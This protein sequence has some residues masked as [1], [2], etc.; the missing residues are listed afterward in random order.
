MISTT[1]AKFYNASKN[2][3]VSKTIHILNHVVLLLKSTE[4]HGVEKALNVNIISLYKMSAFLP[5][6]YKICCCFFLI[7]DESDLFK[8]RNT[9]R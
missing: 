8:A 2:K 6:T 4:L 3:S 7:S 5:K 1:D 9:D